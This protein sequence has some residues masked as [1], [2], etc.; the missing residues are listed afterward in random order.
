[1]Q[2]SEKAKPANGKSAVV[3]FSG[4]LDS[5]TCLYWALDKGYDCTALNICYGQRHVKENACARRICKKLGVKFV[6]IKLNFPWLEGATSL[7]GKKHKI[8]DELMSVIKDK[9]R[10]PS[11][12]VPARN[13]FFV[14]IA[15]SLADSIGACAIIAGPNAVDYSGYPDC[16]PQFYAPLAKAVKEG[17]RLGAEGKSIKILTPLIKLSKA[18]IAKLADKL[19]VPFGL[20]W[21]CYCGGAKP[22]GKC[23]ACKLRAEGFEKAGIED[24]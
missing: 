4:G 6:E 24:K 10:I 22:C 19:G 20:T 16:R 7:V 18:R 21:S 2:V 13:L 5:T 11:T 9:S 12:Y 3:L 17:T 14:S 23:D 15:A 1:M 8:P